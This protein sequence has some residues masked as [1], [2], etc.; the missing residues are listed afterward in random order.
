M[1]TSRTV[2]LRGVDHNEKHLEDMPTSDVAVNPEPVQTCLAP[3]WQAY[4]AAIGGHLMMAN[5]W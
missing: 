5:C 4:G 3:G 1:N 2:L